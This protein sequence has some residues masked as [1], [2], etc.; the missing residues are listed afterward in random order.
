MLKVL[1]DTLGLHN[2]SYSDRLRLIQIWYRTSRYDSGYSVIL[3][4]HSNMRFQNLRETSEY[5]IRHL[6]I[7][8][9]YSDVWRTHP[10]I[11][12]KNIWTHPDTIQGIWISVT[13]ITGHIWI[14]IKASKYYSR[15]PLVTSGCESNHPDILRT[16]QI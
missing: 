1:P 4:S 12:H 14:L 7:N 11:T 3:L 5:K 8:L 6:D 9:N 16:I 15:I 13:N 2:V 10:D